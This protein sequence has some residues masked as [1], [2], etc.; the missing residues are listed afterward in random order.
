MLIIVREGDPYQTIQLKEVLGERV[1]KQPRVLHNPTEDQV[2]FLK[3]GSFEEDPFCIVHSNQPKVLRELLQFDGTMWDLVI[4][5]ERLSM[6]IPVIPKDPPYEVRQLDVVRG[7]DQKKEFFKKRLRDY[8][9]AKGVRGPFIQLLIRNPQDYESAVAYF[10]TLSDR[11]ITLEDIQYIMGDTD[12][13]QLDEA[14][15]NLIF[16]LKKR[17][18]GMMWHYFI[19]TRQYHPYWLYQKLQEEIRLVGYFYTYKRLGVINHPISANE[20]RQRVQAAG[21]SPLED[22]PKYQH[23]QRIL[24]QVNTHPYKEFSKRA[25][26]ILDHPIES[27]EGLTALIGVM[28]G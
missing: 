16:G 14:L 17:K 22:W 18:T 6:I 9:F 3:Y 13:Y 24:D 26:F 12:F 4:Y 20:Y 15:I 27:E 28:Q 25:K 10:D 8:P 1:I 19:H 23:Q 5:V 2:R 21:L 11:P 7:Y